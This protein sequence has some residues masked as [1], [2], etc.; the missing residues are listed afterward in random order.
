MTP[1][2][3]AGAPPDKRHVEP[4]LTIV[5]LAEHPCP[6]CG[7]VERWSHMK[8]LTSPEHNP[9]IWVSCDCGSGELRILVE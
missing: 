4:D 9:E 1:T 2:I 7:S 5:R 8:T 6:D 3:R